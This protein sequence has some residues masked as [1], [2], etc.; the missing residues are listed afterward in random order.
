MLIQ[1]VLTEEIFAN[2]F[3]NAEFHREN[4]V[5]RELYGLE[6][7]LF[8]GGEEGNAEGPRALLRGDPRRPPR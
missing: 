6:D 8:T 5:A 4:N 7:K 1:H 3:D 2:V